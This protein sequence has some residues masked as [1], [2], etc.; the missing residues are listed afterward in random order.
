MRFF[1]RKWGW[2]SWQNLNEDRKGKPKGRPYHGRAWLHLSKGAVASC[3][4]TWHLW[5]R[6]CGISFTVSPDCESSLKFM[7]AFPPFAFWFTIDAR[8]WL[9]NFVKWLVALQPSDMGDRITWSGRD[10]EIRVHD[11]AVWWKL[12]V[13]DYGWTNTRS[14]WRDD[15]WH[16]LGHHM[17]QGEPKVIE[18]RDVLVPMPERAYKASARLEEIRFGHTRLPRFLDRTSTSVEVKM[19]DGEQIPFPGKGT[20]SYNCGADAAF[21]IYGPARTIEDGIG[22]MVASVLRDRRRY[23]L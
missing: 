10:L 14:K 23:P 12:W 21:G 4:F 5:S 9:A 15:C 7:L 16:P 13:C 2:A 6:F 11:W 20:A 1:E 18:E 17:R 22:N 8:G 3:C 19:K